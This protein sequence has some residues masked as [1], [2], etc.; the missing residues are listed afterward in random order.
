MLDKITPRKVV[1]A[2][3]SR[4]EQTIYEKALWEILRAHKMTGFHFRRQHPI[5]P[6]IADFACIAAKIIIELDGNSHNDRLERDATRDFVLGEWG[7]K[8]LRFRN[9]YARDCPNDL[10]REIETEF[11][12]RIG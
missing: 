3:E 1:R 12:M 10:W 2:R 4:R 11:R 8:T 9:V 7:W 6:Y 5:G